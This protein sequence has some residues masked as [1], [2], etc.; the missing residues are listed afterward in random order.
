MSHCPLAAAASRGQQLLFADGT[1]ND[2]G[3]H[4]TPKGFLFVELGACL[5]LFNGGVVGV[6]LSKFTLG[7]PELDDL[8][9]DEVIHPDI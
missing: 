3:M 2:A 9:A 4:L 1:P 8:L 5:E 6:H 7:I